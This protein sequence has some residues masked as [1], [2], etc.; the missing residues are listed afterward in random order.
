MK[1]YALMWGELVLYVG[2]TKRKL[3]ERAS[4]HRSTCNT[5]RSKYIPDYINWEIK[6]L[7]ECSDEQSVIR[8]QYYYD[9]LMPLYNSHRP[10]Q[11]LN[12]AKKAWY[13]KHG[14]QYHR[15]YMRN[16]RAHKVE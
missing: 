3:N 13:I 10:G 5:T 2:K 12:E 9:K 6:L 4:M 14:T 16:Y 1:I 15:E 7:E 11:T 8:E